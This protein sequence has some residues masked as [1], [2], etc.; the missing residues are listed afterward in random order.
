M[1][2][3]RDECLKKMGV[4]S[5]WLIRIK[6]VR[7]IL[8]VPGWSSA[9]LFS[10]FSI[11]KDCDQMELNTL[12]CRT[13]ISNKLECSSMRS[14]SLIVRQN[15]LRASIV[16]LFSS[17]LLVGCGNQASNSRVD[18]S[19]AEEDSTPVVPPTVSIDAPLIQLD[20]PEEKPAKPVQSAM[21]P[22]GTLETAVSNETQSKR[23]EKGSVLWLL[24]EIAMQRAKASTR[25]ASSIQGN[26]S[27]R[28]LTPISQEQ[29]QAERNAANRKVIELAQQVIVKTHTLPEQL[30]SFNTAVL[31]LSDARLQLAITGDSEQAKLLGEDAEA[32]FA[33]DAN[34]FAASES[35]FK[36]LQFTQLQAQAMAAKDAK[37]ALAFARQA[38]L[39]AK[40]FPNESSRAAIHLVAAGRICDKV[41]LVDESKNCLMVVEERFPNSPF[42][43]QVKNSLRRLR[44]PGQELLEFGGST[45]DGKYISIDQFRG[46]PVIIAFWASNSIIFKEDM[47]LINDIVKSL[48]SKAAIIGVN[49]DR[50]ELA[51]EKFIGMHDNTWPHIFYSA[52]NK[53]GMENLIAKYYGVSKVPS[54]WLVDAD[55]IVRSVSVN[56]SELG[57]LLT[58]LSSG[59]E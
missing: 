28:Q 53:R 23:S 29:L 44:L 27:T 45:I 46:R 25:V 49:L 9:Q 13:G 50:D 34:S 22:Q 6:D 4:A 47:R 5:C 41:G 52:P 56:P 21:V 7:Q 40:K 35:A 58:G 59:G 43:E 48:G 42:S 36:L 26:D 31:A 3:S 33:K 11:A 57:G 15:F 32:L 17:L 12:S 2:L 39:F 18:N 51:A 16:M 19:A 55:G 38:R 8:R 54:Y 30:N 10:D 20:V 37:W 24:E 14:G 1:A